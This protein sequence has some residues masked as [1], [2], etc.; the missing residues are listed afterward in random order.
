MPEPAARRVVLVA[1]SGR[2]GTSTVVGILRELGVHVPQPEVAADESNPRGFGE[3]QWAVDFHD[4]L[5]REARVQVSDTR[6]HAW[7]AAATRAAEPAIR[8]TLAA[9]LAEQ[10]AGADEVVVKDPRLTF[11]TGLW[12]EVVRDLGAEPVFVTMLRSPPEVVASKRR[13]YNARMADAFGIASWVNLMLG[14]ERATR[15]ETRAFVRYADLVTDWRSVVLPLGQRLGLAA[16][17]GAGPDRLAA[18]DAFVDPALRRMQPGWDD[19]ALP[20]DLRAVAE[21]AWQ[22]LDGMAGPGGDTAEAH[23]RLDG[24]SARYADLVAAAEAVA[25]SSIMAARW[26]AQ[27]A[28][29]RPVA[30]RSLRERARERLRR[31]R[32]G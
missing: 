25:R 15:G 12:R 4:R 8:R 6:P 26:E 2:S 7:E 14:T 1:G 9:W 11:F 30:A 17:A 24:L 29:R 10:C 32:R 22:V 3:P 18:V 19:L 27:D 16:V 5:L 21:E 23:R 28:A 13:H 31:S 20:A